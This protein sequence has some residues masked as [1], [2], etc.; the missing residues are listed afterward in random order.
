[1]FE[2]TVPVL[3]IRECVSG[4]APVYWLNTVMIIIAF[5]PV[6]GANPSYFNLGVMVL[7][8]AILLLSPAITLF[9]KLSAR[10]L[11]EHYF[12][13]I[14]SNTQVGTNKFIFVSNYYIN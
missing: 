6:G 11:M 12:K 3:F 14:P 7:F 2:N 1:M 10:K 4:L 13:M 5:E 8:L 9:V